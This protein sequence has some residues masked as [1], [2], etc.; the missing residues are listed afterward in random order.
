MDIRLEKR[1]PGDLHPY[2]NNTKKHNDDDVAL[3]AASIERFGFNDPIA[4]DGE[5]TIIEGH[6]RWA[7]AQKLGLT[8]VPVLVLDGLTERQRNLYRIAHNKIA[9]SSTFD[10]PALVDTLREITGDDIN[11]NNLGFSDA[12]AENLLSVMFRDADTAKPMSRTVVEPF[13]IIWDNVDQ[14]KRWAKFVEKL[15]AVYPDSTQGQALTDFARRCGVLEGRRVSAEE[16][17]HLYATE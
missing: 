10:F 5:G 11:V 7:A 8:E 6:G 14:K 4:I 1:S 15:R 9:L 12:V 16:G 3:I 17:E 13:E 2:E